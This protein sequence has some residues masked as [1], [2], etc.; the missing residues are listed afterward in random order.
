MKDWIS[1]AAKTALLASSALEAA[2][3]LQRFEDRRS[4]YAKA[5]EAA[6]SM[7]RTLVVVGAP[8]AGAHTRL[9][10]AYG[11]GDVCLDLG[12]CPECARAVQLDLTKDVASDVPDDSAVVFVSCVLEYVSDPL[13]V[14]QELERMAGHPS[15]VF[16]VVV[17]PWTFTAAWYPGA[18][19]VVQREG[20]S[21]P[22][23]SPVTPARKAG[24]ALALVGSGAL[25][26]AK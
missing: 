19:W 1:G 18:R 10:G 23:F 7:G 2:A 4:T 11:C 14:W 15:R 16:L 12:G 24:M 3:A 9:V 17:Q 6:R 22:S 8:R 20:M 26:L 25:A 13:V 21:R 5:D